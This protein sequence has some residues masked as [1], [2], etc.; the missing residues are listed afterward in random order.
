MGST[1]R[2]CNWC[3]KGVRADATTCPHCKRELLIEGAAQIMAGPEPPQK[4]TVEYGFA[5]GFSIFWGFA[6][7][8][9]I[10]A[11]ILFV[12]NAVGCGQLLGL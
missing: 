8:S 9:L 3:R 10:V 5:L 7:G 2:I 12:L 4:V 6:A 1:E 11:V